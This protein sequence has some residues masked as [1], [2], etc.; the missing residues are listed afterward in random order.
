MR[1]TN[2]TSQVPFLIHRMYALLRRYCWR[3]STGCALVVGRAI[4]ENS[5]KGP[6]RT[7]DRYLNNDVALGKDGERDQY[8]KDI[9]QRNKLPGLF[10][11]A[12]GAQ[13][14]HHDR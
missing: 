8:Q 12:G 4:V 9:S 14:R 1:N 13:F 10:K 5:V 7:P 3:V 11:S 6:D 2:R